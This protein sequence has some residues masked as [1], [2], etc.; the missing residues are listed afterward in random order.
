[1]R[2]VA[3]RRFQSIM[4]TEFSDKIFGIFDKSEERNGAAK[5][6]VMLGEAVMWWFRHS[7]LTLHSCVSHGE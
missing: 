4:I 2:I 3:T 7:C 6:A 5:N 1:M